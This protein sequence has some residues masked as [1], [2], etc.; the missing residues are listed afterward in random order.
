MIVW[1]EWSLDGHGWSRLMT[2]R[3]SLMVT[4][5]DQAKIYDGHIPWPGDDPRWSRPMTRQRSSMVTDLRTVFW[6]SFNDLLVAG[7]G[8][9]FMYC[10]NIWQILC[11]RRSWNICAW[12]FQSCPDSTITYTARKLANHRLWNSKQT[13]YSGTKYALV[14]IDNT[15]HQGIEARFS[16]VATWL[17]ETTSIG[18]GNYMILKVIWVQGMSIVGGKPGCPENCSHALQPDI[19]NCGW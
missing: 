13:Y 3:R 18:T 14:A 6:E 16:H 4:S 9:G 10:A 11:C 2:R 17:H 7:R 12:A 8:W 1:W 19:G 15:F 5:H